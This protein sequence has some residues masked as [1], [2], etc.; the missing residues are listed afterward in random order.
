MYLGVFTHPIAITKKIENCRVCEVKDYA[1]TGFSNFAIEYLCENDKVH[2][3]VF[4]CSYG[5]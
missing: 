1:G 5:A 4:A 2:E 3:P